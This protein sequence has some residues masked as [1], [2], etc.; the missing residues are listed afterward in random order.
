[1]YIERERERYTHLRSYSARVLEANRLEPAAGARHARSLVF[2]A[3]PCTYIYIYI[4]RERERDRDIYVYIYIYIYIHIYIYIYIYINKY[5][6]I[7]I[8]IYIQARRAPGR[9]CLAAGR[10]RAVR[11]RALGYRLFISSNSINY[12]KGDSPSTANI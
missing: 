1:M 12:F 9:A 11:M 8:Y 4:Y 2:A 3:R 5:I 6:Y 10:I 7:Y